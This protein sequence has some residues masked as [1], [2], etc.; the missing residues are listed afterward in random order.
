MK[1]LFRFAILGAALIAANAQAHAHLKASTPAEGT[2]VAGSPT[3]IA[4]TFSEAARLTLVS[5]QKDQDPAQSL[6]AP[7][8]D[9]AA[10]LNVVV[11]TLVPGSYT[12]RWRVLSADDNH[13]TSGEL[14]FKVASPALH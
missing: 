7:A 9:A 5:I 12:L 1:R 2:V 14:H 6:K 13:I 3:S 8:G 11:P 4:L 10:Q